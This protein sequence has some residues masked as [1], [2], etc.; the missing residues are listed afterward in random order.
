MLL[1]MPGW[2]R[3]A[4]IAQTVVLQ[5][6]LAMGQQ[7]V[8]VLPQAALLHSSHP[9]VSVLLHLSRTADRTA[10]CTAYLQLH[11]CCT[12]GHTACPVLFHPESARCS[13]HCCSR[14]CCC[15]LHLLLQPH[16]HLHRCLQH[17]KNYQPQP[18]PTAAR[19]CWFHTKESHYLAHAHQP[20]QHLHALLRVLLC[21]CRLL[22]H[23]PMPG[24]PPNHPPT[25]S[26]HIHKQHN[27][28][29][30]HHRHHC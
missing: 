20:L 14:H 7:H 6:T 1:L 28:S 15:H 8:L 12:A 27:Q 9:P 26:R 29:Q 21:C 30:T 11:Y 3:P 2:H 17:P 18:L 5:G 24:R 23:S 22:H 25:P 4:E 19:C 10:H 16:T 13:T